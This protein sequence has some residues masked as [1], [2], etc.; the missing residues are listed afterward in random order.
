HFSVL[1]CNH[2]GTGS[3]ACGCTAPRLST[4]RMLLTTNPGLSSVNFTPAARSSGVT[5]FANART[6]NLLIEYGEACGVAVQPD[7]LPTIA[8]FP[9][10]FLISGNAACRVRNTPNTLVSNCRR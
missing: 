7:T 1:I 9:R 4:R 2:A 10:L 8:I 6:A 5:A 3:A